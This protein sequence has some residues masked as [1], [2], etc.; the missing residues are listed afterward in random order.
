MVN[1]MNNAY[2]YSYLHIFKSD[3]IKP[4]TIIR[5]FSDKSFSLLLPPECYF[6]PVQIGK[7]YTNARVPALPI[8]KFGNSQLITVAAHLRAA[9][10][11]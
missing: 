2:N 11:S 5:L 3:F 1:L 8:A 10:L 9:A 4:K 6:T 7:H